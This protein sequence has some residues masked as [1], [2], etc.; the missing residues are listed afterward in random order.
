MFVP[1]MI[2]PG[3][4]GFSVAVQV[5]G[6]FGQI[7]W[8]FFLFQFNFYY[9]H[10]NDNPYYNFHFFILFCSFYLFDFILFC[11]FTFVLRLYEQRIPLVHGCAA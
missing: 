3:I 2:N 5:V 7:L 9:Y 4:C 10:Y 1:Y 6:P 11:F 8:S